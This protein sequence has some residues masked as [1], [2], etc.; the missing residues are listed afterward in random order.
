MKITA[1]ANHEMHPQFV[2]ITY[3]QYTS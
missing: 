1:T 3:P 2:E